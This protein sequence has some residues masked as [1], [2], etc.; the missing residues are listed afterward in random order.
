MIRKK[1]LPQSLVSTDQIIEFVLI[2]DDPH[3]VDFTLKIFNKLQ[4]LNRIT[5]FEDGREALDY[6]F[7]RGK[8]LRQP[9]DNRFSV[10]LLDLYL[11]FIDGFEILEEIRSDAAT[12]NMP[13]IILSGFSD[14]D[15]IFQSFDLG[16]NAYLTKPVKMEEL[17]DAFR[18]IGLYW[19]LTRQLTS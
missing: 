1:A 6:L 2:D 8:W 4:I 13:V 3:D 12:H 16:A 17:V 9:R 18:E 14:S 11:P 15:Q 19:L 7:S 10:V 5:V